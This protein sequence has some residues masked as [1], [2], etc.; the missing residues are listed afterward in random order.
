MPGSIADAMKACG[1]LI[2]TDA[3][4]CYAVH[5][6][7]VLWFPPVSFAAGESWLHDIGSCLIAVSNAT[8]AADVFWRV[9]L[10][11]TAGSEA[12]RAALFRDMIMTVEAWMKA[13]ALPHSLRHKIRCYFSG[14]SGHCAL[15]VAIDMKRLITAHI[16][17]G[18]C[19]HAVAT[20][21]RHLGK[22]RG[23]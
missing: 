4:S 12:R 5:W 13:E 19:L 7:G 3:M 1:T 18:A 15:H 8:A 11:Q 17:L 9:Q 23:N 6:P 20:M 16:K 22:A 21:C 14:V 2:S 10:I